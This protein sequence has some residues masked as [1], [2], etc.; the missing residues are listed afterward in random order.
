MFGF[1]FTAIIAALFAAHTTGQLLFSPGVKSGMAI[2]VIQ[3]G[4]DA[5][6]NTIMEKIN[7]IQIPD[8]VSS[9]GKSYM[10]DNVFIYDSTASNGRVHY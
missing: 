2:S 4:K 3:Q 10:K 9:D 6:F 8:I 5:Y 1:R 7:G